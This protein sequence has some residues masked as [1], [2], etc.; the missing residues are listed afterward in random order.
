MDI[1]AFFKE[2]EFD[3]EKE[4]TLKRRIERR[5]KSRKHFFGMIKKTRGE[6]IFVFHYPPK[7]V[8]DIIRDKKD[9]PMNG[10]SAGIGFFRDAIK[11]YKPRAVFCGHMHEYRGMKKIG[12]S[13][14]INPGDAE[15]NKYAIVEIPEDKNKKIKAEFRN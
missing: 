7:G 13:V 8:F 14:I 2:K 11:K 5:E 9:N 1:D 15:K 10:K 6:K 12:S 4:R 3:E